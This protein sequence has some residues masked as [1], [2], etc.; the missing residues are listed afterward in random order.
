MVTPPHML[1]LH[2]L[3]PW[4]IPDQ[5]VKAGTI[6]EKHLGKRGR[7]VNRPKDL[8]GL[9]DCTPFGSSLKHREVNV[10]G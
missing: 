10:L 7:K 8:N 9:Y 2:N 1:L 4:R 5:T 6:P 3:F